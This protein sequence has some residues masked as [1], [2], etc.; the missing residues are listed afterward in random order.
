ME[1][2]IHNT[3]IKA[4]KTALEE[5]LNDEKFDWVCKLH[6]EIVIRICS[7][8]PRRND[9]HDQIAE[10]MDPIVFRQMLDNNCFKGEDFVAMVDYVYGWLYRLCAPVRDDEIKKTHE[11]LYNSLSSVTFGQLV[12]MFVIGVHG[13]LD[14]IVKDLANEQTTEMK[15]IIQ[16]K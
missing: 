10:K 12:P 13:H 2:Q 5:D 11:E 8:I 16:N 7:I 3:Y 9:L 6:R 4:F 1:E 15:K 14:N